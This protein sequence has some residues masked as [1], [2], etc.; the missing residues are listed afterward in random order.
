MYFVSSN[1]RKFEEVSAL[2][3]IPIHHISYEFPEIQGT[4]YEIIEHKLQSAKKYI[5]KI[6]SEKHL[7]LMDDSALHLDGL[8]GFPGV[9]AKD[10]LKIGFEAISEIV[11]KVGRDAKM[12]CQLGLLYKNKTY[13]FIGET[14]GEIGSYNKDSKGFGFDAITFVGNRRM[15]EL[16]LD[17]KNL[18]SARGKSCRLLL[19]F[20]KKKKI[21]KKLK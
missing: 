13:I 19:E 6:D 16:S 21:L 17:E 14:Q 12:M 20:L 11:S 8:H 5:M 7:I 10:F 2:L 3:G 1:S 15:S 4:P 18:I 9:Y